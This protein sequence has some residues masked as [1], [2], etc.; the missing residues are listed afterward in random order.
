MSLIHKLN[1]IKFVGKANSHWY[2]KDFYATGIVS[3]LISFRVDL[4]VRKFRIL[5]PILNLW[6]TYT[7]NKMFAKPHKRRMTLQE[8]INSEIK[9]SRMSGQPIFELCNYKEKRTLYYRIKAKDIR[10]AGQEL[11]RSGKHQTKGILSKAVTSLSSLHEKGLYHG[12]ALLK[13]MWIGINDE[14]SEEAQW[15]GF[16]NSAV[17]TGL[18]KKQTLDFLT[19]ILSHKKYAKNSHEDWW[20]L[21]R[22]TIAEIRG[23]ASPSVAQETLYMLKRTSERGIFTARRFTPKERSQLIYYIESLNK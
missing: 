6:S 13:N 14:G 16:M 4:F 18:R 8:K 11:L 7:D 1:N 22:W 21:A 2:E 10:N 5:Y 20:D 9:F 15:I 23:Q 12:D 17:N 19:L 3:N